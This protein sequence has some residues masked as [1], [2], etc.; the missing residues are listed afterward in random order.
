MKRLLL[1]PVFAVLPHPF[2]AAA[3]YC[4]PGVS[5]G[6]EFAME[7]VAAFIARC[8]QPGDLLSEGTA[9]P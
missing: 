6:K 3:A 8:A 1:S 7:P 2:P 5:A 9:V 4:V